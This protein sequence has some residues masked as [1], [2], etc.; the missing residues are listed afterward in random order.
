MSGFKITSKID[1]N[2]K[3]RLQI[4]GAMDEH[5][6]YSS[7]ET[8]FTDEV[9]FDFQQCGAHQLHRY[10]TLGAVGDPNPRI[11]PQPEILVL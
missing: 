1:D 10:Q 3:T 5:S 8:K 7:I 9:V 6:D 11:S 2:M 4:D